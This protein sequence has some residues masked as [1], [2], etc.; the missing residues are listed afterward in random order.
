MGNFLP[1][2]I[3]SYYMIFNC[4][5]C[6][7]VITNNNPLLIIQTMYTTNKMCYQCFLRFLEQDGRILSLNF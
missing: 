4:K 7:V 2:Y 6:N 3:T 1:N 5:K